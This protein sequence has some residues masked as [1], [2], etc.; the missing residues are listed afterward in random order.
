MSFQ[1]RIYAKSRELPVL[2]EGN[3]FQGRELF[4]AAEKSVGTSPLLAVA[5]DDSRGIAGQLLAIVYRHRLFFSPYLYTYAHV[6]GEGLYVAPNTVDRQQVFGELLQALTR[7]LDRR[8]CLYI[9]FSNMEKKMFGYRHLHRQ[10]FFPV[11]WQVVRNSLHSMPPEER[12]SDKMRLRIEKAIQ[13]GAETH[14]TEDAE[15]LKRFH[16]LLKKHYRFKLRH[17]VGTLS[18][19]QEMINTGHCKVMVTKLGER[20]IGGCACIYDG[21]TAYMWYLASRRKTYA[22]FHPNLITVW[23]AIQYAYTHGNAHIVFMDVGLPWRKAPLREFIL[24]F[25]G[26]PMAKY[27]WFRFFSS[28]INRLLRKFIFV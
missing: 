2:L 17:H 8:Y 6:Y 24:G 22:V 21:D 15:E 7:E 20:I 16:K 19:L 28:P 23:S 26:K 4:V 5:Y 13:R 1:V 3:F 11:A 14:I 10:G 27:R 25:G 12:L 9:E 18:F